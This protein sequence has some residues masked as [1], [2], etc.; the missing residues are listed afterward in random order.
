LGIKWTNEIVKCL[1]AY[2]GND[3][4]KSE[5]QTYTELFE[6]LKSKLKYWKG[7]GI[8]FKGRIRVTNI[9]ILSNLWY[10]GKVQDIP[11]D[12]LAEI[13]KLIGIFIWEGK[14]HQRSLKGLEM[15][16]KRG[17]MQLLCIEKRIQVFRIQMLSRILNKPRE[18]LERFLADSLI[19]ENKF[20]CDLNLLKGCTW[21]IASTIKNIFYKNA[22]K[23]WLDCGIKY[24]PPS[25]N[26]L[27]NLPIYENNLLKNSANLVFSIPNRLRNLPKTLNDLPFPILNRSHADGSLLRSLNNALDQIVY[28]IQGDT[29]S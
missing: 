3:R 25:K 23:A 17:G 21:K 7:K 28:G 20:K 5:R 24:T 8:S 6:K 1:G 13:K 9:F 27:D 19:S 4:Q 18:S 2:V 15:D 26:S 29:D 22:V 11:L 16:Y 10:I 14:Y 12:L